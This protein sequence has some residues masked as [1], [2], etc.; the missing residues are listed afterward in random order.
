MNPNYA[1]LLRISSSLVSRDP[2][3][4][5]KLEACVASL[6]SQPIT[7][8]H[9]F[10]ADPSIKNFRSQIKNLVDTLIEARDGLE[11][12]EEFN[13]GDLESSLKDVKKLFTVSSF[14][15]KFHT[16]VNPNYKIANLSKFLD[17][18]KKDILKDEGVDTFFEGA[19]DV[20]KQLDEVKKNPDK[21]L[22]NGIVAQLESFIEQGQKLLKEAQSFEDNSVNPEG[23]GI[24]IE[25]DEPVNPKGKPVSFDDEGD[26][27]PKEVKATPELEGYELE[28][29]VSHYVSVLQ[30]ALKDQDFDAVNK[31]LKELFAETK[32][33]IEEDVAKVASRKLVQARILPI[34]VRFAH[35]R[36][37]LRPMF[38][39]YFRVATKRK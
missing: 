27:D 12:G 13:S 36:P 3:N 17:K 39:P 14:V 26:K 11:S 20:L 37:H 22:I 28:R 6:T 25:G 24:T 5:F 29:V 30:K 23:K 21:E 10:A 32:A 7:K 34:L 19:D 35:S 38:V 18:A 2:L 31:F 33:N 4:A 16:Q 8:L 9:R 15:V 1:Q